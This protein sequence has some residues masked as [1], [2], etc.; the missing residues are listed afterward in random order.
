ML[1]LEGALT[2]LEE[3]Q[4][5]LVEKERLASL[6]ALMAGIAHEIKNPLNFVNNFAQLSAG[7]VKELREE[8]KEQ[9]SG[10]GGS[11]LQRMDELLSWLEQNVG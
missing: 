2:Q 3:A 10:Q 11:S 5:L 1:E 9:P 4:E 7:L 8:M 6:G